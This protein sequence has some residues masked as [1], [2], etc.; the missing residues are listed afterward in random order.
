MAKVYTDKQ[1]AAHFVRGENARIRGLDAAIVKAAY[2]GRRLLRSRVPHDLGKLWQSV[3]I[4]L[5]TRPNVA[6]LIVDAPYSAAIEF[7]TRPFT[8][9]LKPILAWAMRKGPKFGVPSEQL[10]SFGYAVWKTIQVKGIR[11]QFYVRRAIPDLRRL[12]AMEL[13]KAVRKN[14][15]I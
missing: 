2:N 14:V 3:K 15:T 13:K 4:E 6:A 10:E 5:H 11:A 8:P 9:P 12:L 1:F 7:G